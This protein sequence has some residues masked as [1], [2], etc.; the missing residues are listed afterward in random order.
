MTHTCSHFKSH[1]LA[2]QLAGQGPVTPKLKE[3]PPTKRLDVF[4][5]CDLKDKTDR[6]YHTNKPIIAPSCLLLIKYYQAMPNWDG[7]EDVSVKPARVW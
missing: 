2:C 3:P 4:R 6:S 7:I 5:Q 1:H